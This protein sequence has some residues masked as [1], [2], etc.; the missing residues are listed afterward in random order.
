[1]HQLVNIKNYDNIKM[2]GMYVKIMWKLCENYVKIMWKFC[3]NY[4][5]IMWTLCENY[6]KIM[7]KLCENYASVWKES[8]KL[9]QWQLEIRAAEFYFLIDNKLIM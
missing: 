5:K 1:M 2:H 3:E 4:V 7:W 6:V 8:L 9:W